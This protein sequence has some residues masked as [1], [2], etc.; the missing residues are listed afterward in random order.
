MVGWMRAG[1]MRWLWLSG[2]RSSGIR[3]GSGRAFAF[4]A[5][6]CLIDLLRWWC[7]RRKRLDL[8]PCGRRVEDEESID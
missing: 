3:S 7:E 4:V 8:H 2:S 1:G 6:W 5:D